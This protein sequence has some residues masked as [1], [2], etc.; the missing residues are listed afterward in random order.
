M[1]WKEWSQWPYITYI[2][3]FTFALSHLQHS[4][5]LRFKMVEYLSAHDKNHK[6]VLAE[7]SQENK[8]GWMYNSLIMTRL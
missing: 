4:E 7:M 1:K 2:C 8:L 5:F 6:K 3:Q